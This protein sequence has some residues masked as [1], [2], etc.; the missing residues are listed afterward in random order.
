MHIGTFLL[1]VLL[2]S[3]SQL[4]VVSGF[5]SSGDADS[6]TDNSVRLQL[7]R[8]HD[9]N[10]VN[11]VNMSSWYKDWEICLINKNESS[12]VSNFKHDVLSCLTK[13]RTRKKKISHVAF[14]CN[15][16]NTYYCKL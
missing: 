1:A 5:S 15:V 4:T 8:V 7:Q 13:N 6:D 2:G 10:W 9:V 12:I 11:S 3:S 14:R 16:G